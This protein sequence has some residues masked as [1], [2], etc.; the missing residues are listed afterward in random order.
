MPQR[1]PIV[2]KE[3]KAIANARKLPRWTAARI[4]ALSTPGVIIEIK[5]IATYSD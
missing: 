3:V 1:Q 5:L 4:R 2:P